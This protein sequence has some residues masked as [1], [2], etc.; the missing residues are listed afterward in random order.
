MEKGF[1]KTSLVHCSDHTQSFG[2]C[3][4]FSGNKVKQKSKSMMTVGRRNFA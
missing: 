3:S 4:I 1:E 2:R